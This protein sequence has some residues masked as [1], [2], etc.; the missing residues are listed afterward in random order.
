MKLIAF[1]FNNTHMT[2]IASESLTIPNKNVEELATGSTALVAS[3][4]GMYV[5]VFSPYGVW[6]VD[7]R[8]VLASI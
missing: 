4:D 3:E 2:K 7:C 5:F 8:G 6:R 1:S